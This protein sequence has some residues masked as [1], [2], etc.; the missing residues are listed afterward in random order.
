MIKNY[1]PVCFSKTLSTFLVFLFLFILALH[2]EAIAAEYSVYGPRVFLRNSGAPI[3]ETDTIVA[4][5]PGSYLL[6]IYNGGLI[7]DEYEHVSSSVITLNGVEILS[8]NELNQHVDYIEKTISL[9]QANEFAV[10]VRGKPGGALIINI[11]GTDNTAPIITAS[12][13]PQ[14]NA[15]GWHNTDV[16]VAFDCSDNLSGIASCSTPVTITT[17]GAGQVITGTAV[18]NAGNTAETSVTVN[19][20]KT[21]PAITITSPVDGTLST[22]S[23]VTAIGQIYDSGSLVTATIN[24]SPVVLQTDGSFSHPVT[25]VEG[26]NILT[27]RATDNAGNTAESN[28]S[29]TLQLNQPPIATAQNVSVQEDMPINFALSANDPDGDVLSYQILTQPLHGVISGVAP[30][31]IYTPNTDFNG[32]DSLTYLVNDGLLNSNIATV[33]I[34]VQAVNDAPVANNQTVSATEDTALSISLAGSDTDADALSYQVVTQPAQGSLSGVAPNITYTPNANYNGADSFTFKTHDG[35]LASASATVSITVAAINDAPEANNQTVTTNEDIA[36]AVNLAGTDLDGDAISY[37][38]VTQPSQ[39]TLTGVAPNLTYTPNA[40]YNGV[41]SFTFIMNDGLV[42]STIATVSIT[43]NAINDAPVANNQSVTTNEDAAVA[44]V[45]AATDADGDAITYQLASQPSLGTITGSAPDL[46]YTPNA[47]VNGTDSFTFKAN[48]GVIDSAVVSVNITVIAVNDVP[49]ANDY[50]V[51]AAEDTSTLITLSGTDIDADNLSYQL[52]NQPAH[53][54]LSGGAPNLTYTPN[55]NF[56]GADSFSFIVNDGL[57]DSSPS[58]VSIT[59]TGTNDVPVATSQTITTNEGTAANILLSGSDIDADALTYSITTQPLNGVLTGTAPNITYTPNGDFSGSDGLTFLV[60]DGLLDSIIATVTIDVQAVNDAPVA[61]EQT[62]TLVEDASANV[63]LTATDVDS[64]TL[65]YTI[66]LNPSNGVLSGVLPNLIYTPNANF[67]GMDSLTYSVS[68]GALS[69]TALINFVVTSVN[70]A[71]VSNDIVI[72]TAYNTAINVVLTGSDPELDTLTYSIATQPGHGA[73][74]GADTNYTYTPTAGYTGTDSFQYVANDGLIDSNV[75]TVNV[76]IEPSVS[77]VIDTQPILFGFVNANYIYDVDAQD[78]NNLG[79]QYTLINP[80]AGMVIDTAT[81]KIT[82]LPQSEG[83]FDIALS[84][85]NGA[86]TPVTQ[87]YQLQIVDAEPNHEGDDFWFMFMLNAGSPTTDLSIYI[88]SQYAT[89]GLLEVPG[90]GI[91]IPFHVIPG[92]TL[93]LNLP[94]NIRPF[95]LNRFTFAYGTIEDKGVHISSDRNI[96]VYALNREPFSTDGFVVLPTKALGTHYMGLSSDNN[97]FMAGKSEMGIVAS[98]DNTSVSVSVNISTTVDGNGEQLLLNPGETMEFVLNQGQIINMVSGSLTETR[99]NIADFTGVEVST[100]KPVAVF[101]GHDC[102]NIPVEETACD[103][104]VEQIPPVKNWGLTY[105]SM[106][107]AARQGGDTYRVVASEDNTILTINHGEQYTVLNKGEFFENRI[108]GPVLFEASHPILVAQFSNSAST[109]SAQTGVNYDPAMMLIPAK[110]QYVKHYTVTAPATGYSINYVNIIAPFAALSSLKLDGLNLSPTNFVQI[111]NTDFYGYQLPVVSGVSHTFTADIPFGLAIYGFDDYDSYAYM[112]GM[113]LPSISTAASLSL[114]AQQ[115]DSN[116]GV[117]ACYQVTLLD[118]NIPVNGVRI[119]YSVTGANT[120]IAHINT[121]ESGNSELCYTPLI[122]GTDTILAKTAELNDSISI[123]ISLNL[124]GS[125]NT[126]PYFLSNPIENAGVADSYLYQAVAFDLDANDALSYNLITFPQGM[127]ITANGL[128]SWLPGSDQT[129]DHAVQVEVMDSTGLTAIQ[130]YNLKVIQRNLPPEL[131]SVDLPDIAFIGHH[132]GGSITVNDPDDEV[133]TWDAQVIPKYLS[134]NALS[135][136]TGLISWTPSIENVGIVDASVV[137]SDKKGGKL[138]YSWS[139]NLVLNATPTLV[140]APIDQSI[141][142]NNLYQ[143]QVIATDA[144]NEPLTY[145]LRNNPQ[146]LSIDPQTGL[147]SWTPTA[148]DVGEYAVI[149]DVSDALETVS[150]PFTLTVFSEFTTYEL[151]VGITPQF[152][153]PGTNVDIQLDT[154]GEQFAVSYELMVDGQIEPV[155]AN[156]LATIIA[157]TQPGVYTIQATS[158]DGVQ[159]STKTTYYTVKDATD[160]VLPTLDIS[161]PADG[162]IITEASSVVV[163]VDDINLAAYELT[164]WPANRPQN[165]QLLAQ[166][167]QN[168][169]NMPIATIDTS[170]L[171]NGQYILNLKASDVNGNTSSV[172]TSFIVDGNLKVGNFSFTV[173]DLNIPLAGIPVQ[174]SRTYDSRRRSEKRDLGYGW[175][176]DYQNVQLD[177]SRQLG[178]GWTLNTYY[179]GLLGE[180]ATFCVEPLGALNATVTLP[181]GS[182]ETFDV[183]AVDACHDFVADIDVELE[184][185]PTGNTLSTLRLKDLTTVRMVNGHLER[186]GSN[187]IYNPGLY[188]LTT[189]QG[190]EYH[191]DQ[192]FGINQVIDPNGNTLTYSQSG[193]IHSSGRSISFT[194]DSQG[195]ITYVRAPEGRTIQY[196]YNLFGDLVSVTGSAGAAG[197]TQYTYNHNHGMLDIVDPLGRNQLRN[198]YDDAGRLIAQED[199]NGNRTN[200]THDLLGR[201]SMVTDR[202]GRL[203]Q[204]SYDERGNV[205]STVDALNYLT[206]YS[207]DADDN[208]LSQIDALGNVTIATYDNR[209]NQLTQTDALGNTITFTYNQRGQ[210]LTVAD[211]LNNTFI[212]TYDNVG[213]LLTVQDPLGNIAGNNINAQGLPTLVRNTSGFDT[214]FTYDSYGNKT[215]ETDHLGNVTTFTYDA[216]GNVLTETVQR[217]E[218][219]VPVTDVTTYAYDT[220]KRLQFSTNANGLKTQYVYDAANNK[221]REINTST[222]L[223]TYFD[224]DAYHRLVSTTYPDQS[225][226]TKTYDAEGNLISETDRN[227]NITTYTYDALNRLIQTI[228]ADASSTQT[229]YDAIGRVIAEID[230]NNNRTEHGYDAA[231]RR[232]ITRDALGNETVFTYDANGNL[233]S[234]RDANNNTTQYQYDILD[235]RTKTIY[236]DATESTQSYDV[237]GQVIERTDQNNLS[238]Q[239]AYDAVGRLISVTDVLENI[240]SYTYDEAGNK[241]TQT[242]AL[243]RTTSWTYDGLG[244]QLSRT[245]P[246]GQTESWVYSS[247][248]NNLQSHTDFNG[249]TKNY[250]FDINN[251]LSRISYVGRGTEAF[252]YDAEGNRIEA[253][254]PAGRKESWTYDN[255]NR[256]TNNTKIFGEQIDYVYDNAGNRTQLTVMPSGGV[257]VVIDYS[258]D[259]LNRLET[260]TDTQNQVTTYSYDNVGNR[261]SVLYPNGNVTSYL[262]DDLN[263]LVQQTSND[264]LSNVLTDYQYTLDAAGHRTQIVEASGRTSNYTYDDLYRLTIED[265]TDALNGNYNASYQYDAV[266]NRTASTINGVST[267]YTVDDNDRLIQQGGET[268]TYDN[269]GNTLTKAVDADITVYSYN[270]KNELETADITVLGVNAVTSYQYDVDGIRSKKVVNGESIDF[271][272]DANRA[273]AQVVKE[274]NATTGNITDYL[275]GDDLIKQTQAANDSYYLFD[276]LGS[277]RALTNIT[278]TVTDTY[279]YE[280]FGTLLNQTGSTPNDY[281]FTGEQYD[282]GIDNYYLRARYYDQNIGRFTQQDTWMGNNQD[283]VTLHKYLY[284]NADPVNNIDPTGNFTMVQASATF[285]TLSALTIISQPA[286]F[287]LQSSFVN[288]NTNNPFDTLATGALIVLS[289]ALAPAKLKELILEKEATDG[290]KP[291]TLYHGTSSNRASKI[292]VNG[293]RAA[294]VFFGED[295]ATAVHFGSENN[296]LRTS[297]ISVIEFTIPGGLADSLGIGSAHGLPIGDFLGLPFVD[298]AGSN[299]LERVLGTSLQV[300]AF[301]K[302]LQ[303]GAIKTRRL[304]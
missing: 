291:E 18:D 252:K 223:A 181:D 102:A 302:T 253:T 162:Q 272:V 207:F 283:P 295:F 56:N 103:H 5:T 27:I 160:I 191:L 206:Q 121:D 270:A 241:L 262:Y 172:G 106:P 53:G 144:D 254:N 122:A 12:V 50:S 246:M 32:I 62:V 227:G 224:Y 38:V 100:D 76:T 23:T 151:I 208:Q 301:N 16:A 153:E 77:P 63:V 238:T 235:N 278:G 10:E 68:D 3:V 61:Q 127:G 13:A 293:F 268:F 146:G 55:T 271:L 46:F 202:L 287:S 190:F 294:P 184:F 91:S 300:H 11:D 124:N 24:G 247:F 260:V 58:T 186:L 42:D 232:I 290:K 83:L 130:N 201:T 182:V 243:G 166:G 231:G 82:W 14:A 51:T 215:S 126:A 216:H 142:A 101:S 79:L 297:N 87:N 4:A 74:T 303:S 43:V 95:R 285:A 240:T 196:T 228:Y 218:D 210:E 239:Y 94:A 198:I 154:I 236:P 92:E 203:T 89:D 187:Q 289:S 96:A 266:G 145:R 178:T 168:I 158:S 123:P 21:Q 171:V 135:N 132:Y 115:S 163:T 99:A 120:K 35:L 54:I 98:Q 141:R 19:L 104:I 220:K 30:N 34:D 233:I 195:R 273:Y 214:T 251:R 211:A 90:S 116:V 134:I 185:V 169:T 296:L 31:L 174:V 88:S 225:T 113:L 9:Q 136:T 256:V 221:T 276:G 22:I 80:P 188:V 26:L 138:V 129:G 197:I 37:Q 84:V 249:G 199:N 244:N 118:N 180:I 85:S 66:D 112:G 259:A 280:S 41:D 17:E 73:L 52:V 64:A 194:R 257:G 69:D 72:N 179:S 47:N 71:P 245:L 286:G 107:L 117:K 267:L 193:I 183:K 48:D 149:V 265:I 119:D 204:F 250:S 164:M 150:H 6:K 200:Y 2:T 177:T 281:L 39:G 282:S 242:D 279:N 230:E 143:I 292:V 173:E 213:N 81:G 159:S 25:L 226:A 176:I 234:Q 219:G 139:I 114:V 45:L 111:Q 8:P 161:S 157:P 155:D 264:S 105:V 60:N 148:L 97:Y 222:L 209:R 28:L 131:V 33:T 167:T 269:N 147:L 217:T 255:R 284:A 59:V 140:H 133:L 189:Q 65:T 7:D 70:D 75:S 110:E 29:V 212:N 44:V 57:V 109:D 175:T 152:A 49:V 86:S 304:R 298:I 258:F 277:T 156:G 170:M 93:E 1:S 237:L 165:P 108:E 275:Y 248:N 36:V 40:N 299:G 15:G 192:N 128:I 67:S 137:I 125:G 20:D 288:S 78:P 229:E 261:A 274:T 205:L 263:R